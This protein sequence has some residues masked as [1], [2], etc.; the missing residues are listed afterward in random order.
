M[1]ISASPPASPAQLQT[2]AAT[3]EE[4]REVDVADDVVYIETNAQVPG[5]QAE[6]LR[7]TVVLA[8]MLVSSSPTGPWNQTMSIGPAAAKFKCANPA[9]HHSADGSVL[10]LCKTGIGGRRLLRD[11]TDLPFTRRRAGAVP[12]FFSG[13]PT[14]RSAA[15]TLTC[16]KFTRRSARL[17]TCCSTNLIRRL[18]I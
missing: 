15:K 17:T 4:V 12:T 10:L 18:S 11:I 14:S 8:N 9:A 5:H 6:R 1:Y 16:G 7:G 13:W 2:V 3:V